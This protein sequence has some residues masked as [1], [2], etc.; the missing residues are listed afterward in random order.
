M[1]DDI[2]AWADRKAQRIGGPQFAEDLQQ[3]AVVAVL[4]SDGMEE[5]RRKAFIEGRLRTCKRQLK[6]SGEFQSL[7]DVV[8]PEGLQLRDVANIVPRAQAKRKNTKTYGGQERG[9][10]VEPHEK[11]GRYRHRNR[12]A[13]RC[14]VC[15]REL[16]SR[17]YAHCLAC[18]AKRSYW[19]RIKS[20]PSHRRRSKY[21]PIIKKLGLDVK[22]TK[23]LGPVVTAAGACPHKRRNFHGSTA[24]GV[25]RFRCKDC[26]KTFTRVNQ[27]L[28]VEPED[29]PPMKD[30]DE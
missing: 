9:T 25:R 1:D 29:R 28:Q 17:Q 20:K 27:S 18:R 26:G 5:I 15:G 23:I 10:R 16:P 7:D 21:D 24:A 8:T 11:H 13:G 4:E 2:F 12:E 30:R 19:D 14:A 22:L 3:E 6:S